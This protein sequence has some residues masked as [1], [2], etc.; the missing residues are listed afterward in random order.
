MA[1]IARPEID[2][3]SF[4]PE[5]LKY[6]ERVSPFID[7]TI[8]ALAANTDF[9]RVTR[10][11]IWVEVPDDW[12]QLVAADMRNSWQLYPSNASPTATYR[13]ALRKDM[14]GEVEARGLAIPPAVGTLGVAF[15][16]PTGYAPTQEE[17]FTLRGE[18]QTVEARTKTTGADVTKRNLDAGGA[19]AQGWV[20]FSGLR[21]TALDRLPPAWGGAWPIFIPWGGAPGTVVVVAQRL[22]AANRLTTERLTLHGWWADAVGQSVPGFNLTRVPGLAPRNTYALTVYVLPA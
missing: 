20:S 18:A 16:W 19:P 22:D 4:G 1:R 6:H 14:S 21:F 15:A 13:L 3:R 11:P 2:R 5:T 10:D 12:V 8:T 17:I 7:S 9:V